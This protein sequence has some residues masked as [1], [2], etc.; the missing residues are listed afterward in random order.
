MKIVINNGLYCLGLLTWKRG[1]KCSFLCGVKY[2]HS[3]VIS[4]F[5]VIFKSRVFF[6]IKEDRRIT[7]PA[8]GSS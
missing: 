4:R 6:R 1:D 8:N 7:H 3:S 5:F 2:L